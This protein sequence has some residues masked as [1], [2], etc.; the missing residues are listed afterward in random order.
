MRM[1]RT[2]IAV[3]AFCLIGLVPFTA[4]SSATA[5]EAAAQA[6]DSSA[7]AA[8]PE[9]RVSFKFKSFGR[10]YKFFG[11]VQAAKNKKVHLMRAKTKRGKYRVFKSTRTN[12]RGNYSWTGLRA[13]GWF[14]VKVPADAR[15]RTSRSQLYEVFITH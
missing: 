6:S 9:R 13:T 3:L 1:P 2:V 5:T 15:F 14:Y 4:S 11:K 7:V 10:T 8:L 12:A